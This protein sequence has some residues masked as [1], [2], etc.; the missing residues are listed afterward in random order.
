[1]LVSDFDKNLAGNACMPDENDLSISEFVAYIY[2]AMQI[3]AFHWMGQDN[4]CSQA[5]E[6]I[7]NKEI[8]NL[9]KGHATAAQFADYEHFVP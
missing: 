1:M 2:N 4:H 8:S 5:K 7:D 3:N 9:H 6:I